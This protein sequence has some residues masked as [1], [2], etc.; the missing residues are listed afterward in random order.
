MGSKTSGPEICAK[1]ISEA[2]PRAEMTFRFRP[3]MQKPKSMYSPCLSF[4]EL[5]IGYCSFWAR[6]TQGCYCSEGDL[7]RLD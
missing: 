7:G 1:V 3:I 6:H 2:Y 5:L 4:S